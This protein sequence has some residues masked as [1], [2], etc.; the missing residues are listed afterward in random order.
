MWSRGWTGIHGQVGEGVFRRENHRDL[1]LSGL[2]VEGR[3]KG[4][5][6]QFCV[7]SSRRDGTSLLRRQLPLLLNED[8]G[9]SGCPS[10]GSARVP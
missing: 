7:P 5:D 6:P 4:G 8:N 9:A 2:G 3:K 10:V 1:L